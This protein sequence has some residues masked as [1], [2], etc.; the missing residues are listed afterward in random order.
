MPETLTSPAIDPAQYEVLETMRAQDLI[1][2]ARYNR[3]EFSLGLVGNGLVSKEF[4]TS[5]KMDAFELNE[6]TGKD[7]LTHLLVGDGRGGGHHLP[8]MMALET[9]GV[10]VASQVHDPKNPGVGTDDFRRRQEVRRNGSYQ[11]LQVEVTDPRTGRGM[12]KL[13]GSS[14]FPNEWSTQ[15]VL[16]AVVQVSRTK[17]KYDEV[18]RSN[19]HQA[20]VNGVTIRAATDKKTGKILTAYPLVRK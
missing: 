14:M 2:E 19:T 3:E 7:S 9:K 16:E 10:T 8:T 11:A 20:T 18:R 6:M 13:G 15:D 4:Y 5:G 17:G 1:T 12:K